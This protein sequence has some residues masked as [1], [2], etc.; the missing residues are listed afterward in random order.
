[1]KTLHVA[2]GDSAGGSLSQ[3]I[4]TAGRDDEVLSFLD[5]LSCGPIDSDDPAARSAWWSPFYSEDRGFTAYDTAFWSR[6]LTTDAPLV[7]WVGRH[8]AQELAFFLAWVDRL[9]DR[10]YGV[11]DVT[12]RQWPVVRKDGAAALSRPVQAV[13]HIQPW[14]LQTL[15][16][17]ERPLTGAE[18]DAFGRQW[19]QLRHENAPFRIVT[20]D[21]MASAP[22]DVFDPLLIERTTREW[23]TVLRVIGDTMG[24]NA[25]PYVQVNNLMLHQRLVALVGEGKLLGEGDFDDMLACR[26]RLPG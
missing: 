21:G 17:T 25:E 23:Q 19:R 15:L 16:G 5:D 24:Y 7:V 14:D 26:V 6:V 2:P 22:A 18:R 12:G 20:A 9:G 3:A 11:I 13:A 10:P 1:M 4:R 8:S